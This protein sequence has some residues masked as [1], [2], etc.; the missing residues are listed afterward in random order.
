MQA[1]NALQNVSQETVNQLMTLVSGLCGLKFRTAVNEITQDLIDTVLG[2][3]QFSDEERQ[4]LARCVAKSFGYHIMLYY[5]NK[6]YE[7]FEL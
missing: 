2:G 7:H 6:G 4:H 1:N 5:A 3:Q